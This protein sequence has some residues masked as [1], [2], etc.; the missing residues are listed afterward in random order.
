MKDRKAD[1]IIENG[2]GNQNAIYEIIHGMF[3][4]GQTKEYPENISKII[5]KSLLELECDHFYTSTNSKITR[6][7]KKLLETTFGKEVVAVYFAEFC[8]RVGNIYAQVHATTSLRN[9]YF[10]D[11]DA[12][13]WG[14][15]GS[16]FLQGG[17]NRIH[18]RFI[19]ASPCTGV[20]TINPIDDRYAKGR[21]IVWFKDSHTAHL[22]NKYSQSRGRE[23]PHNVFVR[24]LEALTDTQLSYHRPDRYT[25]LP[26]YINNSPVICTTTNDT[27]F[28]HII[29]SYK[30]KCHECSE[31]YIS[32][33][34]AE[35]LCNDCLEEND[36]RAIC[37]NCGE[38]I[39]PDD[40]F[41]FNDY[42]Y[43]ET[44]YSDIVFYCECCSE[45]CSRDDAVAVVDSRG[46]DDGIVCSACAEDNY[47]E[48]NQ[49]N[50]F[51]RANDTISTDDGTSYCNHCAAEQT[52][53]CG[54]CGICSDDL[55]DFDDDGNCGECHEE[56]EEE[57]AS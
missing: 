4:V 14:D 42:V 55:D 19:N 6:P 17:C 26:V 25:T 33:P 23:L 31:L 11:A 44:C 56:E 50:C 30:F 29:K 53:T 24:A 1:L 37:D 54:K 27:D 43:C 45:D 36:D 28:D 15:G 9:T 40:T 35:Y 51:A 16:C 34:N 10:S 52:Q 2:G 12:G 47:Y 32:G 21:M 18:G 22:I 3:V 39:G 13:N 7:L 8:K 41:G 57:E 46:R 48:C 5:W 49:C 20:I 38:R